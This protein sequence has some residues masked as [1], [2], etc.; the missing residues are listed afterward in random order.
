MA[1]L[2]NNWNDEIVLTEEVI[3]TIKSE[4]KGV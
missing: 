4:L 3:K 2:E 1:Y